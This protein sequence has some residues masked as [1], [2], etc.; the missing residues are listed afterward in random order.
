LALAVPSLSIVAA[1]ALV[2]WIAIAVAIRRHYVHAFR[3][4]LE[5]TVIEPEALEDR[6]PDSTIFRA[7][8][9]ALS[10]SDDRQV[11]Y[12]LDLLASGPPARWRQYLPSLMEHRTPAVRSR[13]IAIL[14]EWHSFSPAVIEKQLFDENLEVRVEAIRHWCEAGH[15]PPRVKLREFLGHSDY[16]TVLA[17]IHCI[18]KY[19]PGDGGLI[20]EPLI[21][22][23]LAV[24]GEHSVGAKTAAAR[25]IA[26]ARPPRATQFLEQ[27]LQDCSI[28]VIREAVRT[29]GE[30]GFEGAIPQLIPMLAHARLRREAREAL[31]KLGPPAF[32]ELR[33]RFQEEATPIEVRSR[34]PRV[35]SLSRRRDA[36]DFLF[37]SVSRF[38][39]RLDTALL[40]GLNTMRTESPEM[41][42]E[43]RRVESLIG[44]ERERHQRLSA[45]RRA[46]QSDDSAS[47]EDGSEDVLSLLNKAISER[48]G[49]SVERVFRLLHLIYPPKDIQ[50]VYFSFNTRPALRASAVEFLDNLLEPPLRELVV[51]L[52]E[53][54][55]ES[56]F[57]KNSKEIELSR[58]EAVQRLLEEDDEWLKTIASEL[59]GRWRAEEDVWASRPA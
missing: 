29:A 56:E 36:A 35:L 34:I 8:L 9:Q 47:I 4:A 23:A 59:V 2:V 5:K 15:Q 22:K 51:P 54:R 48:L 53:E 42:F 37:E 32:A 10:S 43:R 19:R 40:K 3:V 16:R 46:I 44:I 17:A 58:A 55:G 21:E 38:A 39:P 52:V 30:I 11:L 14:T 6:M 31:L 26:I 33:V 1:C 28:E 57:S 49:E 25:G 41:S 50:S 7:L 27:L 45:I 18:T 24:S 20:D 13:T 12:A